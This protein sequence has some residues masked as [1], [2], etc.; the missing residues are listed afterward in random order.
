MNGQ[1][2]ALLGGVRVYATMDRG[3]N[4][5]EIAQRALDKIIHVGARSSPEITAQAEAYKEQIRAVLVHYI[6]VAQKAERDTVCA[7]LSR[8][9]LDDLSDVIRNI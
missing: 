9:G 8:R 2:S 5:D 7:A 6:G 1:I 3:S 4:A